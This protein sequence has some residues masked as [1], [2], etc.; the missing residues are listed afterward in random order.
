MAEN[1]F[2]P[3]LAGEPLD[4]RTSVLLLTRVDDRLRSQMFQNPAHPVELRRRDPEN[5]PISGQLGFQA[6]LAMLP[7]VLVQQHIA[8]DPG[9]EI[10]N[11]SAFHA[12][13]L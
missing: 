1:P 10:S 2:L 4:G 5:K 7:R 11:R 6:E 13:I 12:A 3:D 9:V 8:D